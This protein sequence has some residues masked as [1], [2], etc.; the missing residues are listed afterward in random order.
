MVCL[1]GCTGA[2]GN[3]GN[4]AAYCA[5]L[6]VSA[7]SNKFYVRFL[8]VVG[9]VK[10][11]GT[12]GHRNRKRFANTKTGR[13]EH[14]ARNTHARVTFSEHF[15]TFCG[16]LLVMPS[17]NFPRPCHVARCRLKKK[18]APSKRTGLFGM[19]DQIQT[20]TH[21]FLY[22]LNFISHSSRH[23]PDISSPSICHCLWHF[24]N[25]MFI[26]SSYAPFYVAFPPTFYVAKFLA[27]YL[28]PIVA[29]IL[30][31]HLAHAGFGSK[32]APL[33]PELGIRLGSRRAPKFAI[34]SGSIG[35]HSHDELTGRRKGKRKRNGR[36]GE[37]VAPLLISRGPHLAGGEPNDFVRQKVCR[38]NRIHSLGWIWYKQI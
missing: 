2:E 27:F 23:F 28:A 21:T 37:R 15:G 25:N 3:T 36:G 16:F 30:T 26:L 35:A 11:P 34:W 1:G 18:T 17:R 12:L 31:F 29:S 8:M 20:Q 24:L 13:W 14:A 9:A 19:Q 5:K 7:G 6:L 32:R 33:D 4:L 38:A 22:F 10:D